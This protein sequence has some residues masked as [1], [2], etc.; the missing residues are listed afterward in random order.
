[1]RAVVDTLRGGSVGGAEAGAGEGC[2]RGGRDGFSPGLLVYGG[3]GKEGDVL[4]GGRGGPGASVAV[5]CFPFALPT[6]RLIM[7]SMSATVLPLTL[8]ACPLTECTVARPLRVRA[9]ARK[10]TARGGSGGLVEEPLDF[11]DAAGVEWLV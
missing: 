11:V 8:T 3:G 9:E 4:R 5:L 10:A 1:M 6:A 7:L 2:R